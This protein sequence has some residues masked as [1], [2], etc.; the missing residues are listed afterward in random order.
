MK[1]TQSYITL[2]RLRFF[3]RHGVM[4]QER[5]VGNEFEVSATLAYDATGAMESDSIADAVSYA[6][7]AEVIAREMARPSALLEHVTGRIARALLDSLPAVTAGTV[8]VTKLH[9]P[10]PRQ[11][12]A[13]SFTIAF[14]R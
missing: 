12:A 4:E 14:T 1:V 7:A 3:A 5:T 9:P 6:D 11:A 13:A 2:D 8:T 10:F